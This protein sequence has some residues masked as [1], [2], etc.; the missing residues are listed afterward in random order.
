MSI[1]MQCKEKKTR[2]GYDINNKIFFQGYPFIGCYFFCS[3]DCRDDWNI[4][5]PEE[6]CFLSKNAK[7]EKKNIFCPNCLR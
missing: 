1:C 2:D 5:H 6:D 7:N 4:L 3:K